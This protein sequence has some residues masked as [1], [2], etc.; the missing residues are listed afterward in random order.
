MVEQI[1]VCLATCREN[2]FTEWFIKWKSL[3]LNHGVKVYVSW[4]SDSP[5]PS[6]ASSRML[7]LITRES[8]PDYIP[9]HSSA[10]RSAA[11][12]E[13]YNH[14]HEFIMFLD[15]DV[16]PPEDGSD[17]IQAYL[18]GFSD[19]QFVS[20]GYYHV[21]QH[22][23]PSQY[24]RGFPY[25]ERQITPVVAQYGGWDN[26]PDLDARDTKQAK[27]ITDYVFE[28]TVDIVPKYLGFTGCFMNCMFRREVAPCL[29]HLWQGV[30]RVAYDRFDDIWASLMLKRICDHF[31]WGVLINGE[32]S[33]YHDRLSNP[34][35]ALLAEQYGHNTNENLW[36]KLQ[37]EP[38]FEENVAKCY[39]DLIA[40]F[41]REQRGRM[42]LW[43]QNFI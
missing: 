24:C 12:L 14:G 5:F 26:V 4:D 28:R 10:C 36:D 32:A 43:I 42:K 16:Y 7:R 23:T 27:K 11:V 6:V 21:G 39:D 25:K 9:T 19:E 38:L 18:D 8:F 29:F 1:A 20:G 37:R 17:P 22:L 31:G 30:D 40:V 41:P 15:D 2:Q 3:F 35:K 33:C 34:D 13:A